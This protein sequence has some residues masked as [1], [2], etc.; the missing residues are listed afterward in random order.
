MSPMSP[1]LPPP[2]SQAWSITFKNMEVATSCPSNVYSMR[3]VSVKETSDTE[4]M[5]MSWYQ[6]MTMVMFHIVLGVVRLFLTGSIMTNL[7]VRQVEHT[8]N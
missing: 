4:A 3:L 6:S 7:Y 1:A 8:C 2:C 5:V